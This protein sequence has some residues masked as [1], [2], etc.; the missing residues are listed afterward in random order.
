MIKDL[1]LDAI[2]LCERDGKER[3]FSFWHVCAKKKKKC[4]AHWAAAT[5]RQALLF[6][7]WFELHAAVPLLCVWKGV[8]AARSAGSLP[9]WTQGWMDGW[10]DGA[11]VRVWNG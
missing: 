5:P 8:G 2:Q 6:C 11:L 1:S 7:L 9:G 3:F 4:S 10:M